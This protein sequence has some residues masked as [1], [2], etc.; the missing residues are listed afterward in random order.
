M[1]SKQPHSLRDELLKMHEFIALKSAPSLA[2]NRCQFSRK[3][4]MFKIKDD[5]PCRKFLSDQSVCQCD[6]LSK[7]KL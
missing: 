1:K 7:T 6:P 4:M 3:I 5:L 2:Q